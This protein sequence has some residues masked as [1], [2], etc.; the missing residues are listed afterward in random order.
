MQ[1]TKGI[2]QSQKYYVF[3][4]RDIVNNSFHTFEEKRM[5]CLGQY[6]RLIIST[7]DEY[8]M[9]LDQ[10]KLKRAY[11][12][13]IE[14]LDFQMQN[15]P[16]KQL[17]L[18]K[19][20]F[21]H[22][23]RLI[24]LGK[25]QR[26]KELDNIY[27]NIVI[28]RKKIESTN[29]IENYIT[30]L[31]K[32]DNFQKMDYL[33]EALISDLLEKGYSLTYLVKW[34]KEQQE[35]FIKSN[36]EKDVIVNLR[37]LNKEAEKYT[38]Y[39]K[40]S[41]KD[42]SQTEVA[43]KMLK[44]QFDIK[45]TTELGINNTWHGKE[46]FVAYKEYQA[47]DVT[48]A[49][50]MA[51]KEFSAIKELF[52][53]SRNNYDT[54]KDDLLYGWIEEGK[55]KTTDIRKINNV[56]MLEYMDGSYKKQMKR[57]LDLKDVLENENTKTLERILYTLYNAKSFKVQNRFLNFWSALEYTLYPFPRSTII[58][59]ARVVVPEVFALFYIKNKMNI[60]WNRLT[61]FLEKRED[62]YQVINNFIVECKNASDDDFDTYKVICFF[63]DKKRS[64]EMADELSIHIVLQREC[65]ELYMLL[66]EPGKAMKAID[67]Y[68]EGIKHDLNYIYRLRNQLIHS[69][70][71][72]D[73][74]LEYV[75]MR[76]YRYVNSMLSTILYYEEKNSTYAITDILSS[77]DAT[78]QEYYL[79]WKEEINKKKQQKEDKKILEVEDVYR[80]VRPAYLFME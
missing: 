7:Y 39:I 76:L 73:D 71:D 67:L 49:I 36:Q 60:F 8:R 57:F 22:L 45:K 18:F 56:K 23:H 21:E 48:R 51:H 54:L 12:G 44:K 25:D 33:M 19:N 17:P 53:M 77:I 32:T 26:D 38:I 46:S 43:L 68:Y 31:K 29:L 14:G 15:H 13:L 47:Y 24:C 59:K 62:K 50:D 2:G 20:D 61:H 80:M 41:I 9:A 40:F 5:E 16:F 34:F 35:E 72:I 42:Q 75:S 3:K 11:E 65:M 28:L 55:F 10:S 74:S 1:D 30:C 6:I 64:K 70:K 58:E 79:E 37:K 63:K 66:N 78:Y 27:R 52:G 4:I 69:A